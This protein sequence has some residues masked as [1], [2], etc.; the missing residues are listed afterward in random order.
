MSLG[1]FCNK[2]PWPKGRNN[3]KISIEIF[4]IKMDDGRNDTAD[5]SR[6][7]SQFTMTLPFSKKRQPQI[8]KI[9][10]SCN[11]NNMALKVIQRHQSCQQMVPERSITCKGVNLNTD[12]RTVTKINPKWIT[13][14]NVKYETIKLLE[15]NIEENLYDHLGYGDDFFQDNIKGTIHERNN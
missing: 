4:S 12:L 5:A 11:L 7:T 3:S 15:D 9:L 14:L 13:G 2:T 1:V 8:H 10:P 6:I